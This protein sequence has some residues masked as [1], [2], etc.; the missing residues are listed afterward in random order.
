MNFEITYSLINLS[1][2]PV[3]ILLI[4]APSWKWTD[5]IAQTALI[6]LLFGIVYAFFVG[7]GM[8]FEAPILGAG[9]G[10]LKAVMLLFD[11]PISTLAGWTHYLV[12]DLFVGMWIVRDGRQ[13]GIGA[14]WRAPCLALTFMFGS[15]GLA[16]YLLILWIRKGK[17]SLLNS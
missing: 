1:I 8:V 16:L 10:S 3:W 14:L 12:F 5:K 11:S 7:W 15:I 2:M 9:M 17:V 13:N 4:F 6:P